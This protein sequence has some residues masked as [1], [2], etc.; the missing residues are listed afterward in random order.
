MGANT[1]IEWADDTVNFWVGC[2]Q[3]S[4]ACDHCYA[5]DIAERFGL[6]TWN[7]PPR[8][9]SSAIDTL[10]RIDRRA[11]RQIASGGR[12]RFVFVNSMSD[13]FD[14]QAEPAWRAEAFDA[15]RAAP[16]VIALLLT[17]RIGNAA[18]MIAAAGGLPPNAAVGATFANQG[19]LERDILKLL[20]LQ[21]PLFRF[22]SFEPLL[23]PV[24]P[25]AIRLALE[26]DSDAE[27]WRYDAL[28]GAHW[29]PLSD[30]RRVTGDGPDWPTLD[31]VIVGGESGRRARPLHPMWVR[32]LRDQ[33][34]GAGVAFFFKQWGAWAQTTRD[35]D[36]KASRFA[37][38][39]TTDGL[40][41]DA[42]RGEPVY[43]HDLH[44]VL[45]RQVGKKRAG[46]MLDGRTHDARPLYA[47]RE[48]A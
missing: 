43:S 23:G 40:L 15:I 13:V 6:V 29:L 36:L 20:E 42:R 38:W 22:A 25:T 3:V 14:N 2:T 30:G 45:I 17:K 44:P 4:P 18:R 33:C 19:E 5:K 12:R 35:G 28:G 46:R 10:A 7:G 39:M 24:D 11:A 26:H 48:A 31:W 47:I 41:E 34:A 16:N 27:G 9:T 1:K 8:R 32:A 37:A 21:G